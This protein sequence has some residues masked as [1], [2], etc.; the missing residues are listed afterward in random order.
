MK[1]CALSRSPDETFQVA[2]PVQFVHPTPSVHQ[3]ELCRLSSKP[4]QTEVIHI[5]ITNKHKAGGTITHVLTN[6]SLC[7][8]S[9]TQKNNEPACWAENF[10]DLRRSQVPVFKSLVMQMT[11]LDS[12][13]LWCA[14]SSS[15]IAKYIFYFNPIKMTFS[16]AYIKY[17][18]WWSLSS[19]SR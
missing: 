3:G 10:T 13:S 12:C 11:T 7:F 16:S 1:T 19:L 18:P 15:I 9:S 17:S 6:T 2:N 14:C 4:N 5:C 8:S